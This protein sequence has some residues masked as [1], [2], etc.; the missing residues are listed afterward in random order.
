[1]C[2]LDLYSAMAKVAYK[3]CQRWTLKSVYKFNQLS[4]VLVNPVMDHSNQW[5]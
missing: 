3:G 5:L 2:G 1:V 4:T